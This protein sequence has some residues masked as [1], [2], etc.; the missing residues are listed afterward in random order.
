[1]DVAAGVLAQDVMGHVPIQSSIKGFTS[2][3]ILL[4]AF[5]SHLLL[6]MFLLLHQLHISLLI[7]FMYGDTLRS[8]SGMEIPCNGWQRE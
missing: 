3:T 8:S 4:I 6:L 1:M 7:F 5:Y 2:Y